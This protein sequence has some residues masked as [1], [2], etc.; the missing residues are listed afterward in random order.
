MAL[1]ECNGMLV[2][3]HC[4]SARAN[5]FP[6]LIAIPN[7]FLCMI[8]T[9]PKLQPFSSIKPCSRQQPARHTT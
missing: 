4:Q 3:Q 9:A 6:V 5:S 7:P 8:R 1:T 2:P